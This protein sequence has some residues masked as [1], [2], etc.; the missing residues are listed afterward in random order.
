MRKILWRTTAGSAA[1]ALALTIGSGAAEAGA[2]AL[3]GVTPLVVAGLQARGL[4]VVAT[5]TLDVRKD[6]TP[7]ATRPRILIPLYCLFA[8]LQIADANSTYSAVRRGIGESNPLMMGV[9]ES[10]AGLAA[11]KLATTATTIAA[12]ELL[13]RRNRKAAVITAIALNVAYGAIVA[14]NYRTTRVR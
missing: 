8:G 1:V 7:R 2:G 14:H 5:R 11:A 6:A 10:P 9:A 4:E 3:L 12:T 13:W